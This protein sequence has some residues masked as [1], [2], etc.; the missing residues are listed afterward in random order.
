MIRD[1]NTAFAGAVVDEWARG[2]VTDACVAPGSRSTPMALALAA[3]D[4]IRVHV[5]LDERSASFCAVGLGR[6]TGRPAVVLCTSGS[7][8]ANFHPAVI[9]AHHARVPL[10]VATAD[11]PAELRD[12]GAGQTINQTNLFGDAVR[13]FV[14][15]GV[16]DDVDGAGAWWRSTAARTVVVAIDSPP[17]PVHWNLPF[18]EPLLPTGAPLVDAPG[19]PDGKPWTSSAAAPRWLGGA[20]IARLGERMAA[21][22]RGVI[23]LGAG[24][25]VTGD[26]V[27]QLANALAWPVLAD[28]ISGLR[29]GPTAIST[30]D[31]LIRSEP[32]AAA[33]RPDLVVRIGAPPTARGVN[34]FLRGVPTISLDADGAW[35]DPDRD[36][37]ERIVASPELVVRS[38]AKSIEPRG[39]REWLD[40][41]LDAERAA[42][43]ALDAHLDAADEPFE[44]RI[45]RDVLDAVPDG[46][47]LVV[48]SSMPIR[49]LESFGRPREGVRVIANRGANG[50]DGLVSTAIGVA[51]GSDSPV[52]ALLGDLCFLHDSNGLLG[53]AAR[54]IDLTFVVV[55]NDGG[56]IF[57]FLP[58]AAAVPDQ[59]EALFGTPHGIDLAAL[60]AVHHIPVADVTRAAD[61]H[62]AVDAAINAGGVQM[63]RVKTDRATNVDRHHA[64]WAAVSEATM[65]RTRRPYAGLT[66]TR[67]G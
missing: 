63:V 54:G 61:L 49:D 46:A 4:R 2:G 3:D 39:D 33:Q 58:Q 11:R 17:G 12:V 22:E 28:A 29:R 41:W 1:A 42:R 53:A 66:P 5:F 34:A 43:A 19:R 10:I 67:T 15:L 16:P 65:T 62:A 60:G 35:L 9:E 36:V 48:A 31:A 23:V 14:D 32:F 55:D 6:A 44:G 59:F 26:A 20:E 45:A 7:A 51:L 37:V 47:T 27:D 40:A 52:V 56:G 21:S 50:I 13:W 8:A 57:S 64:A 38:L 18:R 25:R 24:A 30:Y